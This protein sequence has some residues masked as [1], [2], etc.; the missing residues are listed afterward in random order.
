MLY[1]PV[2]DRFPVP[3]PLDPP[4]AALFGAIFIAA[5]FLT[6]RR[7]AY[8]L[9]ALFLAA[10][11]GFA[12]EALGT[13][14]TIP[15]A[16]LLGVL[17]GITTYGGWAS[18][19]RKQPA[20]LLL[21]ALALLF[22][23]TALTLIDAAHRG[24]T[25]REALKVAEYAAYF[26]A[27][28]LCYRLDSEDAPLVAATAVAAIAVSISALA[29]EAIGAPSGLYIGAAIVPRIAGVLE[30]PN[31]LCGYCEIVFAALGSWALIR[32]TLLAD[33]ALVLVICA[34][35]LTFSRAGWVGL[36]AVAALLLWIGGRES[37]RA[38]R[39]G[40]LGLALG[41]A[42]S[43]W[44]AVY[45]HSPVM[46]RAALE[47]SLYSGGVGSRSELWHAAWRMWLDHPL[48]GVGA[49]N[50]ELD[51]PAYGV[52]GVRTHANS[53]YLQSLAEGGLVLFTA[54]IALLAA[55]AV[56]FVR[57]IAR[58]P[59]ALAAVAASLALA[60][61]QTADFL[62]FYPKVGDTWWLLLGT[63]AAAV[64]PRLRSG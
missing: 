5:A 2:V 23:A 48:L 7:P 50:F 15:K 51:L 55:I 1:R 49:G 12:H 38:L 56:S 30:G 62:V 26:V 44:W 18:L 14:I 33:V 25:L 21:G 43:L 9:A 17:L 63:A 3:V 42:G 53:W 11:F 45:A 64:V 46:L 20:R 4:S 6:A 52:F 8:A 36:A 34:G 57:W 32:R 47:P 28:F 40:L 22:V 58:A 54:T 24:P 39:P 27:A 29:Q 31:Q 19:L 13:T 61:H 60:L 16:V 37:R 59:W 41:A 35:V 10:P